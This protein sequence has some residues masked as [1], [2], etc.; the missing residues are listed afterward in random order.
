M[1]ESFTIVRGVINMIQNSVCRRAILTGS[2]S[3]WFFLHFAHLLH[4]KNKRRRTIKLE[5]KELLGFKIDDGNSPNNGYGD[6]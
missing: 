5:R 6:V 3:N 2:R 1:A 4:S